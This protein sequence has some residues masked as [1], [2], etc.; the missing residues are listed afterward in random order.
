MNLWLVLHLIG[1]VLFVGNI[2]TAAFWKVRADLQKDPVI[3]HSAAKNVMLADMVF[4][5]PGLLLIVLSGVVM[6]VRADM[7]MMGL[8]WLTLSLILFA[9]TGIIWLAVLIPLQRAMIRHSAADVRNGRM[10]DAYSRAS[11]YW[12]IF[13]VAAT[14]LPVV[15]LYLMVSRSF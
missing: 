13:G 9:I 3:I 1:A 2:I 8:N 15:I 12:A 5:L 14:L 10:S 4:T 11:R 6:A 7:P